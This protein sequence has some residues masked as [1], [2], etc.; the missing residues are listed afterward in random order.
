M[1]K[2]RWKTVAW[3]VELAFLFL[4]LT[5]PF[6]PFINTKA[7]VAVWCYIMMALG[8]LGVIIACLKAYP[9]EEFDMK[10]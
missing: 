3:I 7:G 9:P 4:A 8:S 6:N 1:K 10:D 5:A 2:N